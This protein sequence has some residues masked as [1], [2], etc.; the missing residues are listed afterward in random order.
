M[1]GLSANTALV[2]FIRRDLAILTSELP[3]KISRNFPRVVSY[4]NARQ[5]CPNGPRNVIMVSESLRQ[6]RQ[7]RD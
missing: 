3:S 6:E 2:V 4:A 5:G 7:S 1:T